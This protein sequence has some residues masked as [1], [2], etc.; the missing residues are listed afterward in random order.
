M[1]FSIVRLTL[2]L[3]IAFVSTACYK[4]TVS[5]QSSCSVHTPL[6][7]GT[8]FIDPDIITSADPTTF[9]SIT[10]LGQHEREMFDDRIVKTNDKW[11]RLT[12]H[13]IEASY[14]DSDS[15]EI[16][17]NPEFNSE[18]DAKKEAIKYGRVIGQIPY[19]LRVYLKEIMI[20]KGNLDF[21]GGINHI[22]I[23]TDK[24][25]EFIA[26]G[27]L[28][29]ALAHE[30]V[31]A[32]FDTAHETTPK[33]LTAQIAD[34]RHI[35]DHAQINPKTEDIAESFLAYLAVRHRLSRIDVSDQKIIMQ[36]IPNRIA[37]FDNHSFNMHP[38][39]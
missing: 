38:I 5:S 36:T 19:S 20:H 18:A 25:K 31:H 23:H 2:L 13:I 8:I 28:E 29:E 24:A 30:G 1:C 17:V 11:V 6:F 35:S 10:Y 12:A 32:S 22:I 7:G 21:G 14:S 4:Q 34:G 39:K 3:T 27:V 37:Y 15:V 9:L 33:W 16:Q 26:K